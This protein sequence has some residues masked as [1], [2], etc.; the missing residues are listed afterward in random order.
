LY[1][2]E[3]AGGHAVVLVSYD[4]TCLKF[5][6]SWGKGWGD[7]GFFRIKD[8]DVLCNMAF[9]DIF[10]Y[11]KDLSQAERDN[12]MRDH[13]E[14]LKEKTKKFARILGNF[15]YKCPKCNVISKAD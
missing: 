11:E 13:A 12:Y 2:N 4:N 15:D 9:Y 3:G 6:N 10:F 14:I 7:N 1:K 8:S 5:L